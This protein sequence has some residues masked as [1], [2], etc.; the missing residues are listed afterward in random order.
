MVMLASSLTRAFFPEAP[1]S[2]DS[3]PVPVT[4]VIHGRRCFFFGAALA[5]LL[6][7]W[8]PWELLKQNQHW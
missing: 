3:P 4:I 2:T 7:A 5:L 8:P 6:Q 1:T